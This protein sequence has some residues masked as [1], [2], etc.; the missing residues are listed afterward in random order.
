MDAS[1]NDMG[2]AKI[3]PCGWIKCDFRVGVFN[4]RSFSAQVGTMAVDPLW[5]KSKLRIS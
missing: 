3:F 1:F 4:I 2:D 5:L